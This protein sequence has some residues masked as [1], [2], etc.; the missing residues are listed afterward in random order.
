MASI[1]RML[2]PESTGIMIMARLPGFARNI[3]LARVTGIIIMAKILMICR[4]CYYGH[5]T[6]FTGILFWSN[7]RVNRN[8]F[9]SRLHRIFSKC[10]YD[11][12]SRIYRNHFLARVGEIII[13]ASIH[14]NYYYAHLQDLHEVVVLP[15]FQDLLEPLS[16]QGWQALLLW[17]R[18]RGFTGITIMAK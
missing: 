13:M 16:W 5:I 14:N 2:W 11:Q 8:H 15:E 12:N 7:Y 3:L 1:Y 18:Y 17:P 6:G 9:L 4:N 10:Y